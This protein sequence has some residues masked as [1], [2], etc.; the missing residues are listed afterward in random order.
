MGES[1][2]STRYAPSDLTFVPELIDRW[3]S[4]PWSVLYKSLSRH[5]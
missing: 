5:M 2:M 4:S 1:R 3:A